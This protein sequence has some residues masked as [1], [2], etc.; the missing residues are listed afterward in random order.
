MKKILLF[1]VSVLIA[2]VMFAQGVVKNEILCVDENARMERGTR[3]ASEWGT[4]TNFTATDM[5]G[6]SHNIQDYLDQGKYV[7]IDFFCAWCGP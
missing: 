1:V 5:D 6:V 7:V 3:G 4:F 2:S